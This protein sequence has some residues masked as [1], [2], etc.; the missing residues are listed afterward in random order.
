MN[1]EILGTIAMI[2]SLV[3]MAMGL[4]VQILK[5]YRAKSTEGVSLFMTCTLLAT[6]MAW[7]VYS[8]KISNWYIL[9]SNAPGAL[10]A[11][12]LLCQFW[13]YCFSKEVF[14]QGCDVSRSEMEH[15][16][17][18]GDIWLNRRM[19]RPPS[20]KEKIRVNYDTDT[21]I[22]SVTKSFPVGNPDD[23]KYR[24]HVQSR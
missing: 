9:V 12:V 18:Y 22:V 11:F 8:L 24:M 4:P 23:G 2:T 14:I 6:T 3:F 13:V 1:P 17:T 19:A 5:I 10:F 16:K 15:L 20:N 21:L 7:C